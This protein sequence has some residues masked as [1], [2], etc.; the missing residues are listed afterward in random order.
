MQMQSSLRSWALC[1]IATNDP[2]GADFSIIVGLIDIASNQE[3]E[4]AKSRVVT[5][6]NN[7]LKPLK[8]GAW[9]TRV[10]VGYSGVAH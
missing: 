3:L 4:S 5:W 2:H 7:A 10:S 9:E 8:N 1:A 6:H